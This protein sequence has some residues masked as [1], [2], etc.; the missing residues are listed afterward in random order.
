MHREKLVDY[1]GIEGAIGSLDF[2][3]AIHQ[4]WFV[5]SVN[6]YNYDSALSLWPLW[7]FF[8]PSDDRHQQ[9]T[10]QRWPFPEFFH[11]IQNYRTKL[12]STEDLGR[13]CHYKMTK[14]ESPKQKQES[15][16][17]DCRKRKV[18]I[19]PISDVKRCYA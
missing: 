17:T 7:H 19:E 13:G 6:L 9:C 1:H 10:G 5:L 15:P 8:N 18:E 16:K 2:R 11:F 3:L 4:F 14:R 12:I